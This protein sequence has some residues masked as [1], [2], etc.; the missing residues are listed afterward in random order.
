MRYRDEDH[1]DHDGKPVKRK[2]F[3]GNG[4]SPYPILSL[5]RETNLNLPQSS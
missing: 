4:K 2:G 3:F 1:F 5:E